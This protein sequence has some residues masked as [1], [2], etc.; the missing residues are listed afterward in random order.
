MERVGLV[1]DFVGAAA[2]S[3]INDWCELLDGRQKTAYCLC[4]RGVC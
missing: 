4:S 2:Q 1:V 3:A